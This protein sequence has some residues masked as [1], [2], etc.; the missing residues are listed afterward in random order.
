MKVLLVNGSPHENG[1]TN[2]ALKEIQAQLT[3]EEIESEIFWIGTKIQGCV[4]CFSCTQTGECV[5]DDNLSVFL[6]KAKY[7]DGFIFGS[8]VYFGSSTGSISA[9]MDRL[10]FSGGRYL[11]YKPVASVV[12]CRRGGASEAFAQMNMYY[13]MTNMPVISSQYWNQVHGMSPSDVE[14]DAEGLQTMRTLGS[15]MAWI[16]KCIENGKKNGIEKPKREA[17]I[18]TNFIR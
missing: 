16:L 3:K 6:D 15:N 8:A 13:M 7:A 9:F 4:G 1:C 17:P 18:S 10:F 2:R 12:S 11:E 5:F 14:Q